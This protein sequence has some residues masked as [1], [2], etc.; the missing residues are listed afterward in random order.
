MR[1]PQG[2]LIDRLTN[3][4]SVF[5]YEGMSDRM[6]KVAAVTIILIVGSTAAFAQCDGSIGLIL[7]D[8]RAGRARMDITVLQGETQIAYS[9]AVRHPVLMDHYRAQSGTGCG[10]DAAAADPSQAQPETESR[11]TGRLMWF[12]LGGLFV[13]LARTFIR[14]STRA[15]IRWKR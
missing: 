3:R 5:G 2:E 15:F 12:L 13:I 14:M 10:L 11:R 8:D 9:N 6:K 1:I 4:G 7:L